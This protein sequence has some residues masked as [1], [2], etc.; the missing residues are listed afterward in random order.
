MAELKLYDITKI[1]DDAEGTETA[2]DKASVTVN[3]GEFLVLVGPSGC[4]KSTTLRMIA[5]LE[6]A[7]GGTIEIGDREVQHLAPSERD[8]AMVFQSYALYK[9]MTARQNMGYGLKH[10][11]DMS[12]EERDRRV[13]ESAELLGIEELL[14]DKPE[15][16]SGGQKQRVALG[17]AI[18]RDPDV[19]LL[20][21]PLS[22]LDAKLRSH[23]R[24]ELQ[25]IQSDL[26]VTTVYVTHDQTE[27][28]TMA[29][30]IAIM[31][32]GVVQQVDPPEV[33]YEHPNNEFVGAFLGS[34]AMNIFDAVAHEDTNG[35]DIGVEDTTLG[36]IPHEAV[37]DDIGGESVRFGVRPEDVHL[38]DLPDD[39]TGGCR[40]PATVRVTEYQGNDNFVYLDVG[41]RSLTARVPPGIYPEPSDE[42]TARIAAEDVYLFDPE[43]T[44]SI[45]TRGVGGEGTDTQPITRG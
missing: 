18:V 41:D 2:V 8:V 39:A 5:G 7:T 3:D 26:G 31:N 21:E 32:N 33:A 34:P 12:A 19:F 9:R 6:T 14:D 16:M 37:E 30:R 24:T 35:Y 4:G 29:D 38:D 28:M 13:R 36:R 20:D 23:M 11:T 44:A 15:A 45:K 43:T 22:N 17:R 27:A 1:Y 25:R 40:F 42:V 10:S